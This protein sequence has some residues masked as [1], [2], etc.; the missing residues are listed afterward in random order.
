MTT[1]NLYYIYYLY[2]LYYFFLLDN[3]KLYNNLFK[4]L[5][6]RGITHPICIEVFFF[7]WKK[8]KILKKFSYPEKSLPNTFA[9]VWLLKQKERRW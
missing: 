1:R 8:L 2:W 9:K 5:D 3:I 7:V 4:D 6:A